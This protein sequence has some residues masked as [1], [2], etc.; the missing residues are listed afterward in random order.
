MNIMNIYFVYHSLIADSSDKGSHGRQKKSN[1]E[2]N[3]I[4]QIL[5]TVDSTGTNIGA[6]KYQRH[7]VP[8]IVRNGRFVRPD[9]RCAVTTRYFTHEV[10]FCRFRSKRSSDSER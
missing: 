9:H 8:T 1:I 6:W 7:N 2:S 3:V 10:D 5:S 4:L